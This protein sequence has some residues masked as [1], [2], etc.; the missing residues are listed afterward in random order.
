VANKTLTRMELHVARA[1]SDIIHDM[2]DPRLP[3]VVT[4]KKVRLSADLSSAK[5]LV[6]AIERTA[7]TAEILNRAHGFL[8]EELGA[9][10]SLRRIPRLT[11]YADESQGD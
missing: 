7:E 8:Q 3:L 10:V 6:S 4:V 9:S 5:V 1:L 2:K 11:F